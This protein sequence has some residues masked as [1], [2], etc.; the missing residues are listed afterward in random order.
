MKTTK[1]IEERITLLKFKLKSEIEL[2]DALGNQ[3][4]DSSK[5]INKTQGEIK[6]LKWVLN[7][8]K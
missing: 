6:A 8:S 4:I 2:Y 3:G 1:E 5:F 7:I